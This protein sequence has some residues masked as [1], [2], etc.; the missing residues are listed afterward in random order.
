MSHRTIAPTALK[1]QSRSANDRLAKGL[2]WFSIGLGIAE[3]FAADR[4]G[5]ALALE[6][7]ETVIRAYGAREIATG[8]AIL[9]S[10]DAT[11]WIWG[12]VIGDTIDLA[13]LA[14][15]GKRADD[16]QRGNVALAAVAVAGVTALDIICARGLETEKGGLTT[17]VADYS[18]RTGFPRPASSM[19]GAARDF[20]VPRDMRV[21]DPLR[22]DLFAQ[23]GTHTSSPRR[24]S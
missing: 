24:P 10:H 22:A 11:P 9:A 6:D 15:A 16:G 13:T 7:Q 14:F 12:R 3:L 1:G 21:P 20:K 19:R 4:L 23:R 18:D 17:A 5:R 2:G 8:V